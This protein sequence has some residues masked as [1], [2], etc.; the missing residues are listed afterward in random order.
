[1]A[2]LEGCG[3][4]AELIGVAKDCLAVAPEDRP[5]D[6]NVVADRIT[7]YLAGVQARVQAAER[8]RAV[9]VARAIEERRCRRSSS[10]WPRRCWP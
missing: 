4:E 8:E 1:M 9:A 7:A 6:A 3:S 2:R 5:R 10:A